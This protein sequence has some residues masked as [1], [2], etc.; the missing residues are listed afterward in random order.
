MLEGS[1]SGQK[2]AADSCHRSGKSWRRSASMNPWFPGSS[3]TPKKVCSV[4]KLHPC[5][6]VF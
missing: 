5:R 3:P 1:Y 4:R 2:Q 6:A